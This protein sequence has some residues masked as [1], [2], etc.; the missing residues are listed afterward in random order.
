M[1]TVPPAAAAA[2]KVAVP[3]VEP[4]KVAPPE[5]T[6]GVVKTGEGPNEVKPEDVE[7]EVNK[8]EPEGIVVLFIVPAIVFP[9]S[10]GVV[11]VGDEPNE[12]KEDAVIV[13]GTVV[14]VN[15]ATGNNTP[16]TKVPDVI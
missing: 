4:V 1:V 2:F 10:V 11:N 14:P 15:C 9:D 3:E 6:T 8:V 13:D 5:L 16:D 12:V 7:T